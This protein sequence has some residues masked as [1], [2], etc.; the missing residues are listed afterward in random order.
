MHKTRVGGEFPL[1]INDW[2]LVLLFA[3]P[4]IQRKKWITKI[5]IFTQIETNFIHMEIHKRWAIG[6]IGTRII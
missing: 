6:S 5:L 2:D 3:M 1:T 4:T